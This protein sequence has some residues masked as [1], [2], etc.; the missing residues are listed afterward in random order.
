MVRATRLT[1]PEGLWFVDSNANDLASW[2]HIASAPASPLVQK[3]RHASAASSQ[4]TKSTLR[5]RAAA[6]LAVRELVSTRA[7][8]A[9]RT[10]HPACRA[11]E[12]MTVPTTKFQS[13]RWTF[14]SDCDATSVVT[15]NFSRP[16]RN[17]SAFERLIGTYRSTGAESSD[18]RRILSIATLSLDFACCN[19]VLTIPT[20]RPQA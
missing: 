19:L 4:E 12:A 20:D 16:Q 14:L 8:I 2:V 15:A 9:E 7:L 6:T 18:C 3:S 10:P 5:L 11:V 13:V 1:P 17:R